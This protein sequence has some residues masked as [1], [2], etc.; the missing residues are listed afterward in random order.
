MT[1]TSQKNRQPV[2]RYRILSGG[3][4]LSLILLF[5]G[6]ATAELP[7]GAYE[8]LKGEAEEVLKIQV[9]N[10]HFSAT[11]SLEPLYYTVEAKILSVTRSKSARQ[12]GESIRFRT[13]VYPREIQI[14]GPTSP[15]LLMN[16]WT[17]QIYLNAAADPQLKENSKNEKQVFKLAAYGRSLEPKLLSK[18]RFSVYYPS[19][20]QLERLL[21]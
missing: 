9:T 7:P 13:F 1:M 11:E 2:Q 6:S 4:L 14:A 3:T 8:Q 5:C 10:V 16:K 20:S 12:R 21:P 15:P 17:G 18:R 19:R